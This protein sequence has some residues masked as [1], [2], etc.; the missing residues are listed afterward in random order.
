MPSQW[1][2]TFRAVVSYLPI[3]LYAESL[4]LNSAI[5]LAIASKS[6]L[7]LPATGCIRDLGRIW[8]LSPSDVLSDFDLGDRPVVESLRHG[9]SFP[10]VN[11]AV[12]RRASI[13]ARPEIHTESDEAAFAPRQTFVHLTYLI[14]ATRPV[15]LSDQIF[16]S[17]VA[18]FGELATL[19][20]TSAVCFS[21]GL[22]VGGLLSLCQVASAALLLS[23]EHVTTFVFAHDKAIEKDTRFIVACGAAVDAHVV[24]QDWN[25]TDIDVVVG[26]SAQL[27]AL[28][29]IPGKIKRWRVVTLLLRTL[30]VVLLIQAALLGSLLSNGTKQVWGSLT[31]LACHMVMLLVARVEPWQNPDV[32]LGPQLFR[33]SRLPPVQFSGRK[34]AL[35]FIATLPGVAFGHGVGQWDWIAG[36]MPDNDRRREWTAEFSDADRDGVAEGSEQWGRLTDSCRWILSEVRTARSMAVFKSSS[37]NFLEAIGPN[38]RPEG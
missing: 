24:V 33:V 2:S 22:F 10:L 18:I 27:H 23:I 8:H 12:L 30:A 7:P 6:V 36:F 37:Q 19:I 3:G 20:G 34:P 17:W 35:A 9:N 4:R 21:Y 14:P 5:I 32:F 29:N 13:I 31:W 11:T 25:A 16:F 1:V 26:Y 28:T 38:P 15:L